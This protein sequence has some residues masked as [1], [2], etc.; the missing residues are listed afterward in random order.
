L[1]F[2]FRSLVRSLA[3][4]THPYLTETAAKAKIIRLRDLYEGHGLTIKQHSQL[5][6]AVKD[7]SQKVEDIYRNFRS[8]PHGRQEKVD[9]LLI[10]IEEVIRKVSTERRGRALGPTLG[11]DAASY[12]PWRCFRVALRAQQLL[13]NL[14]TSR[15]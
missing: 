15:Y 9:A 11:A 10:K 4:S 14:L 13:M 12:R 1:L 7:G 3:M 5:D 2:V 8:D 6:A